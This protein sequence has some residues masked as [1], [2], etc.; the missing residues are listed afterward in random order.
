MRQAKRHKRGT[1]PALP[2]AKLR[3][4]KLKQKRK[5][6]SC[7]ATGAAATTAGSGAGATTG[8]AGQFRGRRRRTWRRRQSWFSV[9]HEA[10]GGQNA[11]KL[12]C[13]FS[14]LR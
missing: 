6:I 14:E 10:G 3:Y 4:G 11:K 5:F 1:Q 8:A 7:S 9:D 13:N 2:K 12:Y